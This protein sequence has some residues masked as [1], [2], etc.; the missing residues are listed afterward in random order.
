MYRSFLATWLASYYTLF[1]SL[2][3]QTA[4]HILTQSLDDTRTTV[5]YFSTP[6]TDPKKHATVK[7]SLDFM[8]D[9]ISFGCHFYIK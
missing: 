8:A 5:Y 2:D 9:R 6:T 4:I 1:D 7:S 3:R